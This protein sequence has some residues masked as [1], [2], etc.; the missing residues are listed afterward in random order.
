MADIEFR[1]IGGRRWWQIMTDWRPSAKHD[2]SIKDNIHVAEDS[3]HYHLFSGRHYSGG[4]GLWCVHWE[5]GTREIRARLE[6]SRVPIH[7]QVVDFP[8][9][10]RVSLRRY[11]VFFVSY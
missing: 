9:N 3:S 8:V 4:R 1:I 6:A 11:N 2:I 5:A 10:S 7:P